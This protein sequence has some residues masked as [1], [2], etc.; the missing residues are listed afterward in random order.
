[1][2][3]RQGSTIPV[4]I[5]SL[6]V[7]VLWYFAAIAMN[8]QR[9]VDFYERTDVVGEVAGVGVAPVDALPE[10]RLRGFAP[11]GRNALDGAIGCSPP[12]AANLP[13][14]DAG[15]LKRKLL[16]GTRGAWIGMQIVLGRTTASGS[17]RVGTGTS[18]WMA[19]FQPVTNGWGANWRSSWWIAGG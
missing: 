12:A 1:M 15:S 17:E 7:L 11:D 5:V 19:R 10:Q 18:R 2:D 9:Q 14:N 4:V 6:V 16:T 13:P 8:W 3:W